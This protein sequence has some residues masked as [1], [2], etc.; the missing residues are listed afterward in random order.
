MQKERELPTGKAREISL[1]QKALNNLSTLI[2]MDN[3]SLVPFKNFLRTLK[4]D[5]V[6]WGTLPEYTL[7][8][9]IGFEETT[10]EEIAKLKNELGE[11]YLLKEK[12]RQRSVKRELIIAVENKKS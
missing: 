4:E 6:N 8:R 7:R 5:I 10:L 2:N 1:E 9:I 12:R 11:D 3:S